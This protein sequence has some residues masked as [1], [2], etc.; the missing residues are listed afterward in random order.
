MSTRAFR[1]GKG[2]LGR[3]NSEISE[4]LKFMW[5]QQRAFAEFVK[6]RTPVTQKKAFHVGLRL[7][8]HLRDQ[9]WKGFEL[10]ANPVDPYPMTQPML[11]V[12]CP[13]CKAQGTLFPNLGQVRYPELCPN[14]V[15]R[16]THLLDERNRLRQEIDFVARREGREHQERVVNTF[17]EHEFP[18]LKPP[19][20]VPPPHPLKE[21]KLY[22]TAIEFKP[23]DGTPLRV[24]LIPIRIGP[25]ANGSF[26]HYLS[27]GITD[28][29]TG[30]RVECAILNNKSVQEVYDALGRWIKTGKFDFAETSPN[31][32]EAALGILFK[33]MEEEKE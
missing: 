28:S 1:E 3:G 8:C 19:N 4:M 21:A 11:R 7:N 9:R 13:R 5:V 15:R 31:P 27:V 14:C 26:S 33:K 6:N 12:E 23:L 22:G 32:V 2:N 17:M 10:R 29:L 24:N 18:S 16:E 30:K 20:F 25:L